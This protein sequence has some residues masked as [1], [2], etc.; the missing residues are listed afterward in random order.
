M[1]IPSGSGTEVIKS[2]QLRGVS[3][4]PTDIITGVSN[5][6]YTVVSII[7]CEAANQ[8]GKNFFIGIFDSDGTSNET[9]VKAFTPIPAK[10][11]FVWN[12]RFSFTGDKRLMV[13][14]DPSADLDVICTYIDQDWS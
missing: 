3:T 8:S 14:T 7:I 12:D 5:H 13:K 1:A 6:I 10:Q 2:T 4:T 9:I 11:T